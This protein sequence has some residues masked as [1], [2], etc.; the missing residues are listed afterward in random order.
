[1]VVYGI[2]N[3]NLFIGLEETEGYSNPIA[4]LGYKVLTHPSENEENMDEVMEVN[5]DESVHKQQ[6]AIL[7]TSSANIAYSFLI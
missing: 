5:E 1:M 2:K 4:D 7:F 6:Y 3:N